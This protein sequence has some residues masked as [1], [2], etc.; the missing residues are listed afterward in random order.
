LRSG[1]WCRIV[2]VIVGACCAVDTACSSSPGDSSRPDTPIAECAA[3]QDHPVDR[4]KELTIVDELVVSDPRSNNASNG[5]WSFRHALSS[6]MPKG[7]DESRF[8]QEWLDEWGRAR[9]FNGFPTDVESRMES[10]QEILVCPWLRQTPSNACNETCTTC[11]ARVLDSAKAPFRLLAIVYRGDL[12]DRPDPDDVSPAGEARL[13]YALTS[14]PADDPASTMLAMTIIFEYGLPKSS[15]P[16]QWAQLWH[17]L[18]THASFDDAYLS[19]LEGLTRRFADRGTAPERTNE[20][21]IL[22]IRTN[23][24]AFNWIWQLRQF[25]LDPIGQLRLWTVTNTPAEALNGS[26]LLADYVKQNVEA[27]KADRHVLP[28]FMLGGSSDA[29]RYRWEVKGVD[30]SARAALSRGTCS[31]CHTL[32]NPTV[33]TAFHITPFKVGT[34]RLSTFL[35]DPTKPGTDEL[36][37]RTTIVK[38][39]LCSTSE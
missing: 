18:G 16:K 17:H 5:P 20:S 31:G 6:I 10:M 38:T 4:F 34:A 32:D 23:E 19:E 1:A 21:A 28:R 13:I 12:Y 25:K 29:L 2:P 39:L 22:R 3:T 24:S 15:S 35:N 8:I 14:G 11:S 27:I 30:E 9:D 33:D 36:S 26:T 37:R 7:A